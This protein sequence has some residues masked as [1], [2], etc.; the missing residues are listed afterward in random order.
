MIF[1]CFCAISI[2][3][4]SLALVSAVMDGFELATHE[5]LQSIH[6]HISMSSQEGNLHFP[7][8]K[9]ILT[10]EFPEITHA[11]PS[12]GQ[13]LLIYAGKHTDPAMVVMKAIDPALEPKDELIGKKIIYPT[14]TTHLSELVKNNRIIIGKK[15]AH[16]L[17]LQPKSKVELWYWQT[18]QE[19]K[20]TTV[21]LSK[22]SAV[23]SAFF[24]TGIEEFDMNMALCSFDFFQTLF[25]ESGVTHIG[26][27]L[28]KGATELSTLE[29]LK[30][31]FPLQIYS[32]K[33]LYPALV[34][35]LKLEKYVMIFI[36][37]LIT[38]VASMNIISLLFMY[39]THK[40]PD[41]FILRSLGMKKATVRSIFLII[42]MSI[43][44]LATCCGLVLAYVA[45]LVLQ[46]YPFIQLPDC[47]YVS[48]LPVSLKISTFLLVFMLIMS[49]SLAASLIAT[50]KES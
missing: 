33:D 19:P 44:F 27:Q 11:V 13:Q 16:A 38:L 15:L 7:A 49:I 45:G 1:I 6:P 17:A 42:G 47:Y 3:A 14:D 36:L 28:Q 32:W 26:L 43:S 25:P 20:S 29:K 50:A 41:I 34:S 37:A 10:Q 2:G 5:K 4:F 8:I 40:A 35:T 12:T 22:K 30:K 46:K 31:R 24:D 9:K 18:G 23:V 39:R 48:H 21:S